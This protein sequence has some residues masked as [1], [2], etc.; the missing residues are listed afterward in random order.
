MVEQPVDL[1]S[2]AHRGG[3]VATAIR[4]DYFKVAGPVS[5]PRLP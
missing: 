4:R 1:Q 3:L 5:W 2:V